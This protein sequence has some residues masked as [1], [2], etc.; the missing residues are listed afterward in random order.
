MTLASLLPRLFERA[1]GKSIDA[2]DLQFGAW[3]RKS[4]GARN[5]ERITSIHQEERVREFV[6]RPTA[7]LGLCIRGPRRRGQ[8]RAKL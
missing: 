3:R 2:P 8:L 6:S 1:P 5:R 7:D 4:R